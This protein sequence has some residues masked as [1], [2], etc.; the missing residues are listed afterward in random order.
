MRGVGS[1]SMQAL[2]VVQRPSITAALTPDQHKRVL[3]RTSTVLSDLEK[4]RKKLK[5]APAQMSLVID[6]YNK[7]AE[8]ARAEAE[9]EERER[10][11]TRVPLTLRSQVFDPEKPHVVIEKKLQRNDGKPLAII[12]RPGFDFRPEDFAIHGDRSRWLVHDVRIGNRGQF[13]TRHLPAAAGTEFGPGGICEHLRFD[14][15]K[16]GTDLA[17]LIEYVDPELEG[18]VFEATIV[19]TSY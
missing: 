2:P 11:A 19:G 17:M 12:A 1:T 15:C 13:A 16:A 10:N 9:H 5:L 8:A 14:I 18:E 4:L 7:E 6:I 3:E